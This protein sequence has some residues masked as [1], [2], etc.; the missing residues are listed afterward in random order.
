MYD[1]YQSIHTSV[2]CKLE[3]SQGLF[4]I[5]LSSKPLWNVMVSVVNTLTHAHTQYYIIVIVHTIEHVS[6]VVLCFC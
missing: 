5:R 2:R 1:N 6:K 3:V 4:G